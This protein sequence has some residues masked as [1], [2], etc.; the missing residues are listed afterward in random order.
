MKLE[1]VRY[2]CEQCSHVFDAPEVG[3]NSYSEFLLRT[4][5]NETAY[6]N[7]LNDSTYEEVD[8]LLSATPPIAAISDYERSKVLRRIYGEVACD[9]SPSGAAFNLGAKPVCPVCG[10]GDMESWEFKD[11]PEFVDADV[12]PVTHGQ[13]NALDEQEKMEAINRVI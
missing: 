5:N 3:A 13:W 11:P 9:P 8:R 6:L 1:L 12:P 4:K 2:T 10:S 7:G